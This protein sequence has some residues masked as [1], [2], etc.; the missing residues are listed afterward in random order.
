[1]NEK[2]QAVRSPEPRVEAAREVEEG[3]RVAEI[4]REI[5]ELGRALEG[6]D[7]LRRGGT[8]ERAKAS[9]AQAGQTAG[10]FLLIFGGALMLTGR[11]IGI[12]KDAYRGA[13]AEIQRL[14][15]RQNAETEADARKATEENPLAEERNA[16][17]EKLAAVAAACREEARQAAEEQ[18]R[19]EAARD[20]AEAQARGAAQ[21]AEKA[22]ADLAQERARNQALEQQLAARGDEQKL[23]AQERARSHELEHQLVARGNELAQERARNQKL[24]DQLAARR[25]DQKLLAQERARDRELEQQLS[26][27]Q[28]DQKSLAQERARSQALELQLVMRRDA[29]PD[30]DRT[31]TASPS[32]RLAS[33]PAPAPDKPV[34]VVL[35]ANDKPVMPA[36]HKSR[37]LTAR[38]TAPEALGN[39]EAERLTAQAR[40]L[41]DQ[42]NI[43]AARSVLQ[44]AAE[45]GSAP[46][47]FLLA[48]TYDRAILS[49][50][51]IF[52]KRGN[53]TKAREL[54]A[55][56]VA[57]GVHEA[58]SRLSALR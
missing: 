11:A 48:E 37:R 43:T 27:R 12:A 44:R 2:P 17:E 7:R 9:L 47:L 16:A 31:A 24:E 56:A 58:K 35:P 26:I 57:G 14:T 20:V 25:E 41:L 40:L 22:E 38:P 46:A 6:R 36:N 39:P 28:N 19:A 55:K 8:A 30:R 33:R 1:M 50:W 52:G 4:A 51:G 10:P 15:A 13:V 45:S 18:A 49:A 29:T 32:D 54:Y 5:D 21:E 34:T 23:L 53:V 42:G 3:R